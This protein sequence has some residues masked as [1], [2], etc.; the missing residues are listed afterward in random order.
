MRILVTGAVGS[1]KTTLAQ[2]LCKDLGLELRSTDPES[3]GG[4]GHCPVDN[5]SE[6]SQ[7]ISDFWIG[8]ANTVIEGVAVPRALRKWHR[9]N[10]D[11]P[12]PADRFI[13]LT[14]SHEALN[15]RQEAMMDNLL[16]VIVELRDWI[17]QSVL[18]IKR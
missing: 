4:G 18:E 8:N 9:D 14:K 12:F 16:N 11:A 17:P 1:G 2:K 5:W 15:M 7:W 13:V 3:L 6:A 10:P